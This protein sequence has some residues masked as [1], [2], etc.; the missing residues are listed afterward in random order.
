MNPKIM[1]LIERPPRSISTA[2]TVK[3]N[4]IQILNVELLLAKAPTKLIT[5]SAE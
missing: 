4:M 2:M 1:G 3:N 5:I